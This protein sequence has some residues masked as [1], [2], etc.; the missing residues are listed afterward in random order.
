MQMSAGGTVVLTE[1]DEEYDVVVVGS[2][3]GALV[4]AYIAATE[5]ATVVVVEKAE[6]FGGT[7]AYSGAGLW[8]PGNQAQRRAGVMD[9]IE[10]GKEYLRATVGDRTPAAL[11]DA[12]LEAGP[13]LV[14]RLEQ[15]EFVEFQCV[16]IPDY[17]DAPGRLPGGRH[18]GPVEL[19]GARMGGLLE[20]MR[21]RVYVERLGVHED[22]DVLIQGQAL[23]GRLLL[24]VASTGNVMLRRNAEMQE[25]ITEGSRVV[26]VEVR[27]DGDTVR[28]RARR[29]VLLA[30]GGF[31]RNDALRQEHQDFGT[32]WTMGV[33]SNI[34][35]AIT[36]A[37]AIGA[38]TDLMDEAWWCSSILCP[39]GQA[40]FFY[41]VRGGGIMV[42]GI[43]KRF[44]N[45]SMSYDR[46][47]RAMREDHAKG[48]AEY[49]HYWI[50]DSRFDDLPAIVSVPTGDRAWF[51]DSGTWKVDD[52][53]EGLAQQLGVP[54]QNLAASIESFNRCAETGV[55]EEFHRGEDEFDLFFGDGTEGPNPCLIPLDKPP[56]LAVPIVPGDLGTKGGLKTD[57]HARVLR[58]DGSVILGLYAAG[59]TMASIMGHAYPGPG[60]PIG[61]SMVFSYLAAL[62][63]VGQEPGSD[64]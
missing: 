14:E 45:E 18:I 37:V 2:G 53:I 13:A 24:A 64:G 39:D 50:L 46:L 48:M 10:K 57:E 1:W 40:A 6:L 4:G 32:A 36:A 49:P 33:T 23:V 52:T 16:P 61:T 51:L 43:G 28:I 8:F 62:D 25:V 30:A 19:Q 5:G 20:L 17:F 12:Y 54:P 41:G 35:Q 3:A 34:G 56:F 27:N 11:Q 31:E 9:S 47:G 60:A 59:N 21:P 42:N 55:D 7:T 58:G 29:G 44:A 26:G 15:N 22:R 38:D 63:M